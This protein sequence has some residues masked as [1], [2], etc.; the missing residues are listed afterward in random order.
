M[1]KCLPRLNGLKP[2]FVGECDRPGTVRAGAECGTVRFRVRI[3]ATNHSPE[4]VVFD[5]NARTV[6]ACERQPLVDP[7]TLG[8]VF[9][10]RLHADAVFSRRGPAE[11]VQS[12]RHDRS[13][14]RL[15][16]PASAAVVV[17]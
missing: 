17:L 1:T 9:G 8:I 12:G 7:S 3:G 2:V 16:D 10:A 5:S 14:A 6:G 11:A 13:S 4:G 15:S